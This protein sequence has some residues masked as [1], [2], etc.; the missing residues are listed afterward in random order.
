MELRKALLIA[1]SPELEETLRIVLGDLIPL[2]RVP[3]DR[4]DVS[5]LDSETLVLVDERCGARPARTGACTIRL[6]V[7]E[8]ATPSE[9]GV[10]LPFP[11][12]PDALRRAVEKLLRAP[13][14]GPAQ[15]SRFLSYPFL[16][17]A[18]AQVARK[19]VST[20]LPLYV[21]GEAGTGKSRLA[22]AIHESRGGGYLHVL[23]PEEKEPLA[24]LPLSSVP[25]GSKITLVVEG[26]GRLSREARNFLSTVLETGRLR[27][28]S[29]SWETQLVCI[30]GAPP[31]AHARSLPKELFY[32]IQTLKLHLPPLR[33]RP[34]DIPDLARAVAADIADRLGLPPVEF[35]DSALERLRNY[36][37]FGN[38]AE[39]ESVL[40]RTIALGPSR[41]ID[42]DDLAF[43]YAPLLPRIVRDDRPAVPDEATRPPAALSNGLDGIIQELAHE[44]RNPMVTIKTFAQHLEHLEDGNPGEEQLVRL[45]EEAVARMDRVLENLVQFTRFSDPVPQ[46]TALASLVQTALE[47]LA[48]EF[49]ER[50]VRV[51]FAPD[52]QEVR[53]DPAQAVYAFEN[54]LRVA[55]RDAADRDVRLRVSGPSVEVEYT[56]GRRALDRLL[57]GS[58][59]STPLGLVFAEKLVR[60]NGGTVGV[61]RS[62]GG[63][64]RVKITVR[65][66]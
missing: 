8:G 63:K 35:T 44:F 50:Q 41:R 20:G 39:L 37:W 18:A 6:G 65:L 57:S 21:S 26:V 34:E 19:A 62:D 55:L 23:D 52:A 56:D 51:E 64:D 48:P 28:D 14:P 31:E 42:R 66:P 45:T 1:D 7:P 12:E 10:A 24:G 60:R 22:R 59:P 13:A 61:E 9:A 54:V 58:G 49:S 11:F 17:E 25:D 36:L 47:R 3:P 43:G 5:E 16:P 30:D 15:G 38:L 40:A 27:R 33:E 4:F 32:R 29:H 46:P 53:V 2:R